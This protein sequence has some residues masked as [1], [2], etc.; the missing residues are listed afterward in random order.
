MGKGALLPFLQK[1][2]FY[3]CFLNA[4][5]YPYS[6]QLVFSQLKVRVFE[7]PT[8]SYLII[9]YISL[10]SSILS[11]DTLNIVLSIELI[12]L[13]VYSVMMMSPEFM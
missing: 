6:I 4:I 8:I 3:L 12:S 10:G 2:V 9:S 13:L 5:A 11:F 7:S 1:L